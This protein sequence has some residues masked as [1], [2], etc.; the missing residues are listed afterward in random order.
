L[1]VYGYTK[2]TE[3]TRFD[4]RKLQTSILLYKKGLPY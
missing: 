2:I 4:F 1:M 3:Y